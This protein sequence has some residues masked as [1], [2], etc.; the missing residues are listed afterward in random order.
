MN[1]RVLLSG[2]REKD[3]IYL[4]QAVLGARRR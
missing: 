3:Y 1:H 2:G 4:P